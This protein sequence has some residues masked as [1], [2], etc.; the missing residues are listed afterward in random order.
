MI[1]AVIGW[2]AVILGL[3]VLL[4]CRWGRYRP[5]DEVDSAADEAMAVCEPGPHVQWVDPAPGHRVTETTWDAEYRA[6][7]N[8]L[9]ED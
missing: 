7:C 4:L 8:E 3:L 9:R 2:G 1:G 6:L 5:V